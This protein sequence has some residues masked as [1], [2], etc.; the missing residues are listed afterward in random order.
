M[1]EGG[2]TKRATRNCEDRGIKIFLLTC[3]VL[4]LKFNNM[5]KLISLILVPTLLLGVYTTLNAASTEDWRGRTVIEYDH[6]TILGHPVKFG[7]EAWAMPDHVADSISEEAS[8]MS[9]QGVY[10]VVHN[11]A[12]SKEQ[13]DVWFGMAGYNAVGNTLVSHLFYEEK[14]GTAAWPRSLWGY[15]LGK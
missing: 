5:K 12:V 8:S 4:P 2:S 15:T 14:H 9:I 10:S 1:G 11:Y 7:W 13:L 6:R 3:L